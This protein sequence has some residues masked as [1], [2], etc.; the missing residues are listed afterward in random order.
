MI[1]ENRVE[2]EEFLHDGCG[3][4][5]PGGGA[6]HPGQVHRGDQGPQ[7]WTRPRRESSARAAL[8]PSGFILEE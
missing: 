7:E 2:D 4:Q 8:G 6:V 3:G 5:V 1:R